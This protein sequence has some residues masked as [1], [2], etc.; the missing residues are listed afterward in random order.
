MAAVSMTAAPRLVCSNPQRPARPS[1]GPLRVNAAATG[2][3]TPSPQQQREQGLARDD[4]GRG[5]PLRL[6]QLP[7]WRAKTAPP[8]LEEVQQAATSTLPILSFAGGG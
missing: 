7:W 3:F 8:Q 5:G 4:T 1:R 2:V 6:P